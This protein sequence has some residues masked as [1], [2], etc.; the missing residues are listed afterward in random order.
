MEQI[1]GLE[2]AES[3]ALLDELIAHATQTS[4]STAISGGRATS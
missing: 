4:T 1:V 3:D 2:R